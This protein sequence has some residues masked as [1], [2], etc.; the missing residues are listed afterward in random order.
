MSNAEHAA[1]VAVAE[2]AIAALEAASPMP[3][4][5]FEPE[6]ASSPPVVGSAEWMAARTA[7]QLIDQSDALDAVRQREQPRVE[8]Y[9]SAAGEKRAA[10][11][12]VA[13]MNA[14]ARRL[15]RSEGTVIQLPHG[16]LALA[17][18]DKD[19]A[20]QRLAPAVLGVDDI[21]PEQWEA[22]DR[23]WRARER[24]AEN[25]LLAR[26]FSVETCMEEG[27]LTTAEAA[28]LEG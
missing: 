19:G 1:G 13:L 24:A 20:I 21:R 18:L 28:E 17:T 15:G 23:E 12:R 22:K 25:A 9:D 2:H 11:L 7:Q 6:P 5:T 10:Y 27:L 4:A 3:G 26:S 8:E 14:P 16:A